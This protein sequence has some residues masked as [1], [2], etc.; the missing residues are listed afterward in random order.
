MA[1]KMASILEAR[2]HARVSP[3]QDLHT[4]DQ[5]VLE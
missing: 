3:G 2:P 5:T 1:H 4:F